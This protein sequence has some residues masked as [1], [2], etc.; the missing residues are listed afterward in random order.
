M[1]LPAGLLPGL[2]LLWLELS[3]DD[4]LAMVLLKPFPSTLPTH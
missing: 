4:A 3:Y 1:P 2:G